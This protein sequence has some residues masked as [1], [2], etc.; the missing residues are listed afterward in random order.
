MSFSYFTKL[1]HRVVTLLSSY[2]N[3]KH[4]AT[5]TPD[6]TAP[7]YVLSDMTNVPPPPFTLN[8]RSYTNF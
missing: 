6:T 5:I 4:I 1:G 2:L 3:Q 7:C 8:A